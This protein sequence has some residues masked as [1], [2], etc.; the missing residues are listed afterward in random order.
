MQTVNF[1]YQK[2]TNLLLDPHFKG[3]TK[4]NK[5]ALHIISTPFPK[6]NQSRVFILKN[7]PN[8]TLVEYFII[9]HLAN[10]LIGAAIFQT[11]GGSINLNFMAP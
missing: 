7:K 6:E 1:S 2:I 5:L 4:T 8:P 10:T 3:A 11:N 9:F